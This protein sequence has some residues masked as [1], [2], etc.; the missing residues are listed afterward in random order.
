[1]I[2]QLRPKHFVFSLEFLAKTNTDFALALLLGLKARL[3]S[4]P[5]NLSAGCKVKKKAAES[6]AGCL[7]WTFSL[8]KWNFCSNLNV[9]CNKYAYWNLIRANR[10]HFII[11]GLKFYFLYAGA[12]IC[13]SFRLSVW[14]TCSSGMPCWNWRFPL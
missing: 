10:I 2:C 7:I 11:H 4:Y 14:Q 3:Q 12:I 5:C 8:A 13:T 1:M 6:E 9:Q